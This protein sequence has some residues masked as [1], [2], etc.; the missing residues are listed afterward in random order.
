MSV[1]VDPRGRPLGLEPPEL[2]NPRTGAPFPKATPQTR[3][4]RKREAFELSL[5]HI[6]Q[7]YSH[8]KLADRRRLAWHE[9]N[10][11]LERWQQEGLA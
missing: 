3:K 10:K 1:I 9:A 8:L 4:Q 7:I 6:S 11:L 5:A 2:I